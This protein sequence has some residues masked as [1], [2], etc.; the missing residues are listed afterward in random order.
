MRCSTPHPTFDDDRE[1]L[2]QERSA[3]RG[4]FDRHP[5]ALYPDAKPAPP[6]KIP[7]TDDHSDS[8]DDKSDKD[9]SDREEK[10]APPSEDFTKSVD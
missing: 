10:R 4:V 9:K 6:P 1:M 7:D 3:F 5:G 8:G 2:E